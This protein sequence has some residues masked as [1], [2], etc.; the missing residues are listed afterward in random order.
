MAATLTLLSASVAAQGV[1]RSGDDAAIRARLVK[2]VDAR[3]AG[4]AHAEVVRQNG[5]WLISAA[6]IARTP[7]PA[8]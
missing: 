4:D 5:D 3:N 8:Q 1:A 6:R 2:Y 7:A